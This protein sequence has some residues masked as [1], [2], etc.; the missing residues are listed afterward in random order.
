MQKGNDPLLPKRQK[1]E[2]EHLNLKN[3]PAF[4]S[5]H[6]AA[7]SSCALQLRDL[8]MIDWDPRYSAQ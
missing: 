2:E 8:R 1:E 6:L 5:S 3:N 4:S 7:I